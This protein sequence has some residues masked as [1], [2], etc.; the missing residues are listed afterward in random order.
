MTEFNAILLLLYVLAMVA[1]V[2]VWRRG[3]VYARWGELAFCVLASG[4][5]LLLVRAW[6]RASREDDEDS[7]TP[8]RP[9]R[10]VPLPTVRPIEPIEAEALD[11]LAVETDR[12]IEEIDDEIKH[13]DGADT[14]GAGDVAGDSRFAERLRRLRQER[15]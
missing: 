13:L 2:V 15:P 9:R 7:M 12:R 5:V 4:G 10:I 6:W 3:G 11:H 14:R 8:P 1:S